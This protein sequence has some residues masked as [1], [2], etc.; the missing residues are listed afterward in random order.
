MTKGRSYNDF[1]ELESVYP[2]QYLSNFQGSVA[3]K[4]SGQ[5]PQKQTTTPSKTSKFAAAAAAAWFGAADKAKTT[6]S[7]AKSNTADP[8]HTIKELHR[9]IKTLEE[10][11]DM[12]ENFK[13]SLRETL[14]NFHPP[15]HPQHENFFFYPKNL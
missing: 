4:R 3:T 12:A 11:R 9:R 8:S 6:V 10:E 13:E 14:G 2:H 5:T 15:K 1:A 7:P